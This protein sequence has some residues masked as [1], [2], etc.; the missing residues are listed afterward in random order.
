MAPPGERLN[1]TVTFDEVSWSDFCGAEMKIDPR[2]FSSI[3]ELRPPG[4]TNLYTSLW[5]T[6][7]PTQ[8]QP[9]Y[10]KALG[11]DWRTADGAPA[12]A[13]NERQP[14]ATLLRTHHYVST[15]FPVT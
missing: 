5:S 11:C 7:E 6:R 3:K 15:T 12:L 2:Q 14:Y 13:L 1:V 9:Y 8:W 4:T 10:V